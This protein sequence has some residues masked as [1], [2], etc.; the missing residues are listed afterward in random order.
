MSIQQK[1]LNIRKTII[2]DVDKINKNFTSTNTK[3]ITFTQHIPTRWKEKL[4]A[5]YKIEI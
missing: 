5:H 3:F 2:E 1:R 4:I